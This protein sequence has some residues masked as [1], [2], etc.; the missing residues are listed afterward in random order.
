MQKIFAKRE[1][2]AK[3]SQKKSNIVRR[4]KNAPLPCEKEEK[5]FAF[6]TKK[7]YNPRHRK[8]FAIQRSK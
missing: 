2:S 7:E 1:I 5:S 6:I 3:H 4:K 8:F